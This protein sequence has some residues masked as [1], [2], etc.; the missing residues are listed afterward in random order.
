MSS[1]K[2]SGTTWKEVAI[3]RIA[4]DV[5]L[6]VVERLSSEIWGEHYTPLVGRS[7]VE[8]MLGKFLSLD[9]LRAQV[10]D[11][12][13]YYLVEEARRPIGYFAFQLRDGHE[14]FLSKY[15]IEKSRRG[16]GFGRRV[17]DLLSETARRHGA[18][19]IVLTVNKGNR[20]ALAVYERLGFRNAG[21]LVTDIGGGFVMD[22]YRL[23]RDV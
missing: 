22:D 17:M 12:Y 11:G 4:S 8:Y 10:S 3:R 21:A 16:K 19:K 15:Y 23:E 20:L 6:R 18:R 7:Q 2:N 13:Q 9:A 5:D 1:G 14:L